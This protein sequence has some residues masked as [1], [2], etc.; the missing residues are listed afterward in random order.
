MNTPRT[1]QLKWPP[2]QTTSCRRCSRRPMI[3][4][5]KL[6]MP[7]E[8]SYSSAVLTQARYSSAAT[9]ATG[10]ASIFLQFHHSSL[11]LCQLRLLA[12]TS[13]IGFT[14]IG[15]SSSSGQRATSCHFSEH[16][17]R[18]I[19]LFMFS[20][21]ERGGDISWDF[22]SVVSRFACSWLDFTHAYL[23]APDPYWFVCCLSPLVLVPV[24]NVVSRLNAWRPRGS[25]RAAVAQL[26]FV[27]SQA[28]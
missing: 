14:R 24:Q 23:A 26:G 6:W 9:D 22:V 10:T 8:W 5:P 27:R 1:L 20:R 17:W 25:R 21:G 12:S 3:G 11:S 2:R 13:F 16:F 28:S 4:F 7:H 18:N 19:L 15:S